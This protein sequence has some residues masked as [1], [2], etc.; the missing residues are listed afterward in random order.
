MKRMITPTAGFI[1]YGVHKDGLKDPMGAP[2]IDEA[3]VEKSKK[4]LRDQGI[5]LIEHDVV[6]ASKQEA[7]IALK[8]IEGVT[9]VASTTWSSF[10]E[11][12]SGPL[13]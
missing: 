5:R 12:G 11:P 8:K 2:F 10:P 4:A 7:K 1:V 9:T 6:I 13:I 3:I